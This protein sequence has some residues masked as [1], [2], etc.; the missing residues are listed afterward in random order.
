MPDNALQVG[1]LA[2]RTGLTIRSLHHYD[3]IG[4]LKP[5]LHSD[6]G[7]RLYTAADVARLQQILSLRQLGFSLDEIRAC[8]DRPG[9]SPLE[10]IDLHLARLRDQIRL[11]QKLCDRLESLALLLR[12]SSAETVSADEF[13]GSIQEMTMLEA[14]QEKYFTPEQLQTIKARRHEVGHDQLERGQ[15][16]WAELIAALRTE[17]DHGTDPASPKVQALAARWQDLLR[18][19]TAG[20]PQIQAAMK[21]LWEEQGDH[22]AAQFGAKYDSRPVWAYVTRAIQAAKA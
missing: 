17:M 21:K 20:D 16:Q 5:S 9:F 2:R 19:S 22:L 8:L 14:L 4:L 6:A 3:A 12:S 7:Y 13:L 18:Q 15:E 1:D 11:Q 10:V